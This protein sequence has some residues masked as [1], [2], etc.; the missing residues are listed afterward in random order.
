M[1]AAELFR[2]G[3]LMEAIEAVGV[4]IRGNPTDSKRRTFLFEL[5]CFAGEYD[6]AQKHLEVLAGG[7]TGRGHRSPVISRLL[8]MLN[9]NGKRCS[10]LKTTL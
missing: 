5:L 1:T 6:R 4:E 7:G 9:G 10:P 8:C 3:K 2:E